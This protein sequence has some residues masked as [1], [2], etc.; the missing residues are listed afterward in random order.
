LAAAIKKA[1]EEKKAREE[2][3]RI[4]KEK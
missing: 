4:Q 2:A 3:E 1:K